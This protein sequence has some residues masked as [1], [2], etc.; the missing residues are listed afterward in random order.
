ML[1]ITGVINFALIVITCK[2]SFF[3]LNKSLTEQ[4]SVPTS[5]FPFPMLRTSWLFLTLKSQ[6]LLR[7]FSCF[8]VG[9]CVSVFWIYDIQV[10]LPLKSFFQKMFKFATYNVFVPI[11][12]A[13]W[14]SVWQ[15]KE[16]QVLCTSM[17]NENIWDPPVETNRIH[18]RLCSQIY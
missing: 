2:T 15:R 12:S 5:S 13:L 10:F 17:Y 11:Y 7:K 18:F 1:G 6:W 16:T 14:I 4:K 8:L 3:L 9:C